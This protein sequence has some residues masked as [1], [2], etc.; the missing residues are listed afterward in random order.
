MHFLDSGEPCKPFS[1]DALLLM[2]SSR[3]LLGEFSWFSTLCF[4]VLSYRRNSA[5]RQAK[6]PPRRC[7]P[8]GD[9]LSAARLMNS[10]SGLKLSV[11]RLDF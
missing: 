10:L 1:G 5:V 3:V 2:L 8:I 7:V 4:V 11:V 9:Y 6:G